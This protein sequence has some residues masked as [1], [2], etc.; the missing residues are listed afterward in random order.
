MVFIEKRFTA[1][2]L[3]QIREAVDVEWLLANY[4]ECDLQ[5]RGE[6]FWCCCP[7]HLEKDRSFTIDYEGEKKGLWR[8]FGCDKGGNIFRF[9]Q[10]I[11]GVDFTKAVEILADLFSVRVNYDD[12]TRLKN[13]VK[14][15]NPDVAVVAKE[16]KA[17]EQ[18][19]VSYEQPETI[20]G[21]L[22]YNRGYSLTSATKIMIKHSIGY[23]IYKDMYDNF[24]PCIA[25]HVYNEKGIRVDTYREILN[26]HVKRNKRFAENGQIGTVVLK[27]NLC[28][29]VGVLVEGFWDFVR[30]EFF[31]YPAI[32]S[33]RNGLTM[34]QAEFIV[35]NYDVVY[36][37]F[38][39][40]AGGQTGRDKVV[41]KLDSLIDIR[42]VDLP[43][44][45]DPDDCSKKEFD[46]AM[47]NA[48]WV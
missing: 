35:A 32:T 23:A 7:L 29:R 34:L 22:V 11:E 17:I 5:V 15:L 12:I 37:A 25:A 36:I 18:I 44:D 41:K 48:G 16:T 13:K 47:S 21:Y 20:V 8:C 26:P 3:N 40:D 46:S 6:S 1:T 33:F 38:D 39:Q 4:Y 24:R 9:I 2:F 30:V 14:R 10:E 19:S 42:I 27:S 28:E 45:L 31:G 43:D